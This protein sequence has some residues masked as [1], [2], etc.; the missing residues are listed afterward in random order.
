MKEGRARKGK[1]NAC[2][3]LASKLLFK[4]NP[5][6]I[7]YQWLLAQLVTVCLFSHTSFTVCCPYG[8]HQASGTQQ[9][10]PWLG[11]CI[12]RFLYSCYWSRWSPCSAATLSPINSRR[13]MPDNISQACSLLGHPHCS[14]PAARMQVSRQHVQGLYKTSEVK[15][16]A[17]KEISFLLFLDLSGASSSQSSTPTAAR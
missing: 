2:Y 8:D 3:E 14:G 4:T 5:P 6:P 1:H 11:C 17:K 12:K 16:G 13:Q 9:T 10:M 15:K 7:N